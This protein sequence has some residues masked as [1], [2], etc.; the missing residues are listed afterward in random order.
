MKMNEYGITKDNLMRTLPDVLRND[1]E[2]CALAEV[3]ADQ[4][5]QL[6]KDKERVIIYAR[7]DEL[8]EDMLDLLAKDFK[9]DWWD[10]N[11]TIDEKRETLK[12]SWYVHRRLGT[13]AA[14]ETAIS[15]I[16]QDTRI[17]EWFEYGGVPYHFNLL[18]DLTYDNADPVKHQRV[19]D[20]VRFYKNLR[21]YL[22]GIEYFNEG[23]AIQVYA[24]AAFTGYA[25]V[26]SAIAQNF[27]SK[28]G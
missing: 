23:G 21:S 13:V 25:L 17:E 1:P 5:V 4:L 22:D 8:P 20:R 16:Y 6:T 26:Q 24:G 28:G 7:I 9:V 19:L 10:P 14:V 3:L 27:G 18:I 2:M 12:K 15:P 11:Y